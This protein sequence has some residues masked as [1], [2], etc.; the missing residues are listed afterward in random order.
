MNEV[1]IE[2]TN[3]IL[4]LFSTLAS[5]SSLYLIT[6]GLKEENSFDFSLGLVFL[7]PLLVFVSSN[8]FG[9]RI[10]H[11]NMYAWLYPLGV[12]SLIRTSL[13]LKLSRAYRLVFILL[14]CLSG[15]FNYFEIFNGDHRAKLTRIKSKYLKKNNLVVNIILSSP[16][17][18]DREVAQFYGNV[19]KGYNTIVLDKPTHNRELGKIFEIHKLFN[20]VNLIYIE[21]DSQE[22][23]S[24]L[25]IKDLILAKYKEEKKVF[26]RFSLADHPYLKKEKYILENTLYVKKE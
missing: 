23:Q 6:K 20:A 24:S 3:L 22:K 18:F 26:E 4:I 12:L 15:F 21:S 9:V 25:K 13:L 1:A 2:M 19:H 11:W 5:L 14:L 17:P 16:H 10:G 7:L 8:L